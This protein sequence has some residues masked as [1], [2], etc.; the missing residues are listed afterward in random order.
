MNPEWFGD[1]YDIVKRYL[2]ENLKSSG[3]QVF[4]DPMITGD[5]AETIEKYYYFIGAVPLGTTCPKEKVLFIDPDT[6]IAHYNSNQ[7]ITIENMIEKL[8]EYEIV[9]AFDQSFSRVGD[10]VQ[11][12]QDKLSKLSRTGTFGFYYNS[13]AKF[14]FCCASKEKLKLFEKQ[15]LSTGLPSE[16]ILK[17]ENFT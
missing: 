10:S 5:W 4:A 9:F 6:G 3:Y 8:A 12:M 11:K 14:L 15:L 17:T 2:I 7:H 16:R 1:S 13:H